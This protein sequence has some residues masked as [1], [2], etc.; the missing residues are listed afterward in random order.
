[1]TKQRIQSTPAIQSNARPSL[2]IAA[3]KFPVRSIHSTEPVLIVAPHPD[4]ETLGCGGAIAL[5]RSQ[6]CPVW[7][8]VITDGTQSHPQSRKYPHPRLQQLRQQETR[9]ALSRLGIAPGAT[10]FLQLPD[11]E[12]TT[13]ALLKSNRTICCNYL[14]AIAPKTIFLPW[15]HDPHPDH[16]ATWQLLTHAMAECDIA[17]RLIEYPI[18]DWDVQQSNQLP[19]SAQIQGWRLDIQ[20][21]LAVKQQAIAAYQSQTTDLIDDDPS[22]FRLSPAMLAHFAQSWEVYFEEIP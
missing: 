10:T 14:K 13:A 7:V 2:A 9:L 6:G 17:A 3:I 15:R 22:G 1:M 11:G 5:L 16:Q 12:M 18:W 21:V 19:N 8:L 4:D 20:S